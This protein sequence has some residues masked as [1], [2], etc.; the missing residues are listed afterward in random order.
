[1]LFTK[2]P[3]IQFFYTFTVSFIQLLF[4]VVTT[5]FEYVAHGAC[6]CAANMLRQHASVGASITETNLLCHFRAL[7][8]L[9]RAG[10]I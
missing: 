5:C 9:Q 7:K 10:G 3:L 8:L 2:F 1:M 6:S 4:Q